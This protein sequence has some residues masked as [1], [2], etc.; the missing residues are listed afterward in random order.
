MIGIKG[1]NSPIVA[2][3]EAES[4]YINVYTG[5]KSFSIGKVSLETTLA[6]LGL[7]AA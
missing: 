6:L 2:I 5:F 7:V 1:G 4:Y 3:E